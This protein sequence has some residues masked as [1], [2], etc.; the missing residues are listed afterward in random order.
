MAKLSYNTIAGASA[1]RLAALSDG[2]F[3]IAM[4]LLV[5]D[6]R[7][8]A[9][10]A[11]H[12]EADL[13]GA[14]AKLGPRL[15]MYLMSFL[16]L[17]IF[18]LGQQT[19]LNHLERAE[20]GF[21]WI[22]IVFLFA[23]SITPFS[24]GLLAQFHDYRVALLLY[25]LNILLLGVM[26]Y[27]S[28]CRALTKGLVREDVTP[29]VSDAIKRRIVTAQALYAAAAA[30]CFISTYLSLAIMVAVQLNYAIAPKWPGR[31]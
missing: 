5:L 20:R 11:I 22:H 2:A 9:V 12:S 30:L 7:A 27:W 14:L 25:W 15:G 13:W 17:G 23:V 28:W 18:W 6:L 1:D 24:T 29:H 8:P 21:A 3:S 31:R 19:Q 4:T 10:E 16:T 26:L